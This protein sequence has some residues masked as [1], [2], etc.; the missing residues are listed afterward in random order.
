LLLCDRSNSNSPTTQASISVVDDIQSN[1]QGE[2]KNEPTKAILI[3]LA[4][5]ALAIFAR[6]MVKP[7]DAGIM[8]SDRYMGV[9]HNTG[10]VSI[11]DTETGATQTCATLGSG[12][13]CR[14]RY[15]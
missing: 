13:C 1:Q 7:A 14:Q 9:A 6:Y 15:K 10:F 12:F 5:I 3:E 11:I 8:R 2:R 4:L